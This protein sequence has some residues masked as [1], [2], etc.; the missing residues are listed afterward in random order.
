MISS[1]CLKNPSYNLTRE[2][3][4][5]VTRSSLI[6]IL[7]IGFP[8]MYLFVEAS[9]PLFLSTSVLGLCSMCKTHSIYNSGSI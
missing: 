2:I 4:E 8:P 5:S 9:E 6:F 7:G 3:C 1:F